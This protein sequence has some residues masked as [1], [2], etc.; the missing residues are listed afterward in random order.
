M[1]GVPRAYCDWGSSRLRAF[2][3][4]SGEVIDRR[5]GPGVAMLDAKALGDALA[6]VLAPWTNRMG[7]E[8]I[9]LC[10]MVGSRNGLLDVPYV[11]TPLEVAKWAK[12]S[13]THQVAGLGLRI[14]PGVSGLSFSG[15]LDVM[16]GEETQAFGAMQIRPELGIG[17]HLILLP[18]TH[19]KWVELQDGK[20]TRFQT[21]ITGELYALLCKHSS[22]LRVSSAGGECDDAFSFGLQRAA[23]EELG[24]GLFETR[25]AQLL[26]GRS[27]GWA[28]GFLSGLLIGAEIHSILRTQTP[29]GPVSV[30][31]D[32]A[33]NDL[34]SR[35]LAARELSAN[36]MDGE[37]CAVA[38]LRLLS[39]LS[40][41]AA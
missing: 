38:G 40:R 9:C 21:F 30:I 39:T 41:G 1:S 2:L 15:R 22:L 34:Y 33:L 27:D 11:Q 23:T 4:Q 6:T 24:A 17:R 31:G 5:E 25:T 28:R 3:E 37:A 26:L 35:A 12:G 20:L 32:P 16:R 29:P 13:L 7:T 14:A 8:E 19:S 36:L 10:G 18:G